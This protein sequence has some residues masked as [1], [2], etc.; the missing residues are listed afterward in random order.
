[1]KNAK[2]SP[3]PTIPFHHQIIH[4]WGKKETEHLSV[5]IESELKIMLKTNTWTQNS[6]SQSFPSN[7]NTYTWFY[8]IVRILKLEET[9]MRT[10]E[11]NSNISDNQVREQRGKDDLPSQ[12]HMVAHLQSWP[13]TNK[14]IY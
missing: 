10:N 5:K 9:F 13:S 1:M 6:S 7:S 14:H 8:K 4:L 12:G 11:S 3:P 2:R